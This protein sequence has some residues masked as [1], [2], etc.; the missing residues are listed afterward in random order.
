MITPA[1]PNQRKHEGIL[2]EFREQLIQ[3]PHYVYIEGAKV[4]SDKQS[5]I[6]HPE[7][8][9]EMFEK[10]KNTVLFWSSKTS[11]HSTK[12]IYTV[13]E[14]VL[15]FNLVIDREQG[16]FDWIGRNLC[17]AALGAKLVLKEEIEWI[18][19]P[20]IFMEKDQ[21]KKRVEG[22]FVRFRIKDI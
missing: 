1:Y 5:K 9:Y 16:D 18:K 7:T 4:F 17:L 22:E 19:L 13:D 21:P 14:D 11:L 15:M 20:K 6:T 2:A 10:S 3:F 8:Y 12:A